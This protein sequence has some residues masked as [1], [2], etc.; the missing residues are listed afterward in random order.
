MLPD[1]LVGG[2]VVAAGDPHGAAAGCPGIVI[3]LP[4]LAAGLA[5]RRDHVIAPGQLAGLGVEAGDEVAHPM[6]AAGSTHHNLVLDGERGGGELQIHLLV[7]EIGLPFDLAGF[8]VGGDHARRIVR[9][10]DDERAPQRGAA[11]GERELLLLGIH[12]PHDPRGIAGAH[13]DLVDDAPQIDDVHEAILDQRRRLR[14]LFSM[15][16]PPIA[17]A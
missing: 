4:G 2:D 8:L 7:V 16:V 10:R 12:A 14:D 15:A 9:G 11:V 3:V 17:T 6:I 5:R 13:V 1:H